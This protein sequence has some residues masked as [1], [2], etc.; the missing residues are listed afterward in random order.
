MNYPGDAMCGR[1]VFTDEKWQRFVNRLFDR[2]ESDTCPQWL[3]DS[4]AR[5]CS[6]AISQNRNL[7]TE[8]E[9]ENAM[10]GCRSLAVRR[11]KEK[12]PRREKSLLWPVE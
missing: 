8:D 10:A 5:I 9:Y 1:Y 3:R 4:A 7:Y 11:S 2:L 6:E 12:Q